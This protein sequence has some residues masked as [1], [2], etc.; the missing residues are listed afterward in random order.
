MIESSD[1]LQKR[2]WNIDLGTNGLEKRPLEFLAPQNE[3]KFLFP[4]TGEYFLSNNYRW[5]LV[6]AIYIQLVS[7]VVFPKISE[8]W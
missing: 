8:S 2:E 1:S 7:I 4:E 5:I 6:A 3:V